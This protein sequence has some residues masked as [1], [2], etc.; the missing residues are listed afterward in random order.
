MWGVTKHRRH[1]NFGRLR[2]SKL[3]NV[4]VKVDGHTFASKLE[5][6]VYH[7]L[8]ISL[9][10]GEIKI[11]SLQPR[12]HLTEAKILYVPDFKCLD[13]RT[14]E[15]FFVEAKGFETRDWKIKKRLWTKYGPG[16]LHIWNGNHARPTLA[17]ILHTNR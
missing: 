2:A 11:L 17:Q 12:V 8:K 5:A 7:R 4:K 1:S 10:A 13:L 3:G 14:N 15:I 9:L 6:S 16:P